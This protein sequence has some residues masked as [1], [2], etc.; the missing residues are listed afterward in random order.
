MINIR[1]ELDR[2]KID[3]SIS[4]ISKLVGWDAPPYRE[5]LP[6]PEKCLE[7]VKDMYNGHLK[8]AVRV[9]SHVRF[10]TY[11]NGDDDK[12][13]NTINF[14]CSCW[15]TFSTT[16]RKEDTKDEYKTISQKQIEIEKT[17]QQKYSDNFNREFG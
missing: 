13:I 3:V 12:Q 5:Q 8:A 15:N 11:Y 6:T 9:L 7:L 16:K 14:L 17:I 10:W 1:A 4:T 2:S